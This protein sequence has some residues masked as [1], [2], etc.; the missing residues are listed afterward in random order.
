METK[1]V[2]GGGVTEGSGGITEGSG[3]VTDGSGGVT[4]G[5]VG[6]GSSSGSRYGSGLR[7][8]S[9]NVVLGSSYAVPVCVFVD[10]T[11]GFSRL[12]KMRKL[13]ITLH[14]ENVEIVQP[15]AHLTH[16][17]NYFIDK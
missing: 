12:E 13:R 15:R 5:S 14:K 16:I 3:G 1:T 8:G 10:V 11:V 4:K 9:G 7:L 6:T 2:R 17:Y